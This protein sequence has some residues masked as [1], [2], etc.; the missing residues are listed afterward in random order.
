MHVHRAVLGSGGAHGPC[1]S[2]MIVMV[3]GNHSGTR[4]SEVIRPPCAKV[5]DASE[6]SDGYDIFSAIREGLF[7]GALLHYLSSYTYVFCRTSSGVLT[8][9]AET[10]L[11]GTQG[12]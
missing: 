12:R 9:A 11:L 3:Q 1:T 5:G 10:T 8:S 2:C 7:G 4:Y 6:F